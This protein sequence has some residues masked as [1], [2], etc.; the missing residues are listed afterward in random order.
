MEKVS[1]DDF[2]PDA[3]AAFEGVCKV[4]AGVL[5]KSKLLSYGSF[6]ELA[7]HRRGKY[8]QHAVADVH[9]AQLFGEIL[10]MQGISPRAAHLNASKGGQALAA[11]DGTARFLAT[12]LNDA[13][14][15]SGIAATLGLPQTPA[16]ITN[17]CPSGT[18]PAARPTTPPRAS[19]P[20]S[21][22]EREGMPPPRRPWP[23]MSFKRPRTTKPLAAPKSL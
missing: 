18:A 20:T 6:E 19:T 23:P 22:S 14:F 3:A 1:I 11:I 17:Q 10:A 8:V 21:A 4:A 9:D 2:F 5:H 16:G 7:A 13:E 15:R 12:R